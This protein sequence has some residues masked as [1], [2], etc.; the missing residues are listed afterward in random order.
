MIYNPAIPKR[1]RLKLVPEF[2]LDYNL[3]GARQ[4]AVEGSGARGWSN[5]YRAFLDNPI[6]MVDPLGLQ[7][8]DGKFSGPGKV[9]GIKVDENDVNVAAM[10]QKK[11]DQESINLI[12]Q[13]GKGAPKNSCDKCEWLQFVYRTVDDG[14]AKFKNKSGDVYPSSTDDKPYRR[15]DNNN[16]DSAFS[17]TAYV[18]AN[19]SATTGALQFIDAPVIPVAG[20]AVYDS[21]LVCGGRVVYHIHWERI[22]DAAGNLKYDNIS[23]DPATGLPPWAGDV[24]TRDNLPNPVNSK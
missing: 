5:Q 8:E 13:P 3:R 24:L 2:E 11:K 20:K 15:T 4:C 18:G 12:T 16:K 21:Y 9:A 19:R 17:T 1:N 10:L 23:G 14:K 7:A 6:A 22:R